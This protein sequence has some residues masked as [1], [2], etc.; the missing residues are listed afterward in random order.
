MVDPSHPLLG[1]YIQVLRMDPGDI[2]SRKYWNILQL[3]SVL[4]NKF[5]LQCQECGVIIQGAKKV[6]TKHVNKCVGYQVT[7]IVTRTIFNFE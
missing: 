1:F 3:K 5:E 6:Y 4:D 2:P 7:N